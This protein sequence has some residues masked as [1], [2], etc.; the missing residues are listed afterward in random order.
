[1]MLRRTL[2]SL[3]LVASAG[4][5]MGGVL[6]IRQTTNN[7]NNSTTFQ[8]G[9]NDTPMRGVNAGGWYVSP[10]WFFSKSANKQASL[11]SRPDPYSKLMIAM[12]NTLVVRK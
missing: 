9:E 10:A 5:V 6:S 3:A 11:R 12:D 8:F 7:F 2:Y 1:M 4:P